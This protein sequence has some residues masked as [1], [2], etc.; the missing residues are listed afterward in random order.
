MLGRRASAIAAS[1]AG[2]GAEVVALEGAANNTERLR[3]ANRSA[4]VKAA[5]R[6]RVKSRKN[7]RARGS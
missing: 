7:I 3:Q 4:M 5:L 2:S 6:E 1:A